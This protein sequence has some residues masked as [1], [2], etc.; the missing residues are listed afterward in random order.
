[1]SPV[2]SIAR[3]F[4]VLEAVVGTLYVAV[5]IALLIGKYSAHEKTEA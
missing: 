5:V 1:M 4:T 2:S 3:S